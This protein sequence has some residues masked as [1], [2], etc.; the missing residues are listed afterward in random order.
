MIKTKIREIKTKA[1]EK[2]LL[3]Y[4]PKYIPYIVSKKILNLNFEH[5]IM[6]N[7]LALY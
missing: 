3:A 7:E 6:G 5:F 1:S 2:P 4:S